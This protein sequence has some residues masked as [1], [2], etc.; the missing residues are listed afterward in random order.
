MFEMSS[1]IILITAERMLSTSLDL[2]R[3]WV[4]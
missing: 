3:L 4:K 1:V 2:V